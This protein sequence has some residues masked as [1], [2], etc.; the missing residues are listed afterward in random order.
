MFLTVDPIPGGNPNPYTNPVDPIN[1]FDLDGRFGWGDVGN[2]IKNNWV[3]IALT[4]A[5]FVPGLGVAA[6]T[7]RALRVV[8]LAARGVT[9]VRATRATSW[10]A[11]R[12][13]TGRGAV[14][15]MARNGA[16]MLRNG[17]RSYRVPA[18]KNN[19]RSWSSNL[20][21]LDQGWAG[22][23]TTHIVHR[24]PNRWAPWW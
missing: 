10:V 21:Y 9:A 8:Q 19:S 18:F 20:D 4:A 17:S 12:L 14:W 23:R 22:Y 15:D 6:V 7:L 3:D 11:G 5:I 1:M 24:P 13:W 16:P 2:F